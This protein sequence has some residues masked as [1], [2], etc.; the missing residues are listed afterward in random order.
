[1]RKATAFGVF[2]AFL[3]AGVSGAAG[4]E[5]IKFGI[6][7]FQKVLETSQAGKAAQEKIQEAGKNM[8][9]EL[10]KLKEEIE[11]SRK[12]LQR[13]ALV[14]SKEVREQK[15]RDIRIRI[16]DFKTLQQ[17]YASEFKAREQALIQNIQDEFFE[18]VEKIGEEQGYTL[19]LEKRESAAVYFDEAYDLTEELI[20]RY[21]RQ[22]AQTSG[23]SE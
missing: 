5:P 12:D 22:Y 9:A 3:L 17:K 13:E 2:I 15:E 8:E 20:R 4:A 21:D 10:Q 6:V 7:D 18:L 23:K 1:M 19:I 11:Q 16:N 14:M